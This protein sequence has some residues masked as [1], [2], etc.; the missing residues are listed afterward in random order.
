MTIPDVIT[1]DVRIALSSLEADRNAIWMKAAAELLED[2]ARRIKSLIK[3][4]EQP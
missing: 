4:G 1:E 2:A 3:E